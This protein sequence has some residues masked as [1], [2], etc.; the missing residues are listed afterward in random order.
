MLTKRQRYWLEHI[1]QAAERGRPLKAYAK[2]RGLS[3][4]ALYTAKS[5]LRKLGALPQ[6]E[7]DTV[8]A[9][10]VPVRIEPSAAAGAVCR[11]RHPGG[12]EL[13]CRHWPDPD[14]LRSLMQAEPGDA[15]S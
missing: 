3:V 8:A 4:D 2:R 13:E 11:L 7:Q 10:L 12:W 15:S 1:K 14:W 6:Q 5:Q 9:E